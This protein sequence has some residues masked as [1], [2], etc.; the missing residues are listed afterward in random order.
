MNKAATVSSSIRVAIFGIVILFV[1]SIST[2]N[3]Q[4]LRLSGANY[5][6][7]WV[8][9][10]DEDTDTNY[11]EHL[12]DKIKVSLSYGD[13]ALRSAF[14]FSDPSLPNPK[15][16]SYID[17]SV[18][19]SKDPVNILYGRFNKTFG[20]GLV[21][22]QFV[23]EDFKIDKSLF[24]IQSRINYFN[25]Q[26]TLLSGKP[27]NVFFEENTYGI[28]NDDDTTAQVRG[29]DL[30]T[31][32]IPRITLGGRYVRINQDID[33]IPEA[34]TELFGGNIGFRTGPFDAYVE[35]AQQLG[36]YP[37]LGGRL[38]GS[39]VLFSSSLA[40]SGLGI[41]FQAMDYDTIGF[42][43]NKTYRYNE[44]VTPIK[45]GISVNRG[46]DEIGF[47]VSMLYS[48]F[49]FMTIELDNNKISTH[50]T[51]LNKIEQIFVT[52]ETMNAV[53]EQAA[54]ITTYPS[55]ELEITAAIEKI[56]KQGIEVPIVKKTETKPHLE[57][58]YNFGPFFVGSEY[59]IEYVSSDTSDY[60]D[61]ALALSI[62]KPEAFVFTVRYEKRSRAP[63]WLVD[64]EKIGAET[65]WPLAELS[66]DLT[67]R[68]N[69]RIRAGAE[70]GGLVCTGGVCRFEEPF[71]GIKLVLTSIF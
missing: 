44:P 41:S 30:E 5:G 67:T 28:K 14:F 24:G 68:H 10:E 7:Y 48:P 51:T 57:V 22:N 54:K 18:Q 53:I 37:G 56:V 17:Y 52:N 2:L 34:F 29:V 12:E 61:Q 11:K 27:R 35:Y 6:E 20:R 63:Q 21:L 23:D 38:K 55:Y 42:P 4:D 25:T 50:D 9:F 43:F 40:L 65:R 49:D 26:L 69:L 8:F 3:A 1:C 66:L 64:L 70:K 32:I 13:I 19:Y 60:Y 59:G 33:I 31:K 47:G 39:A 71:K 45:T 36:T 15:K 62:G 58:S 16:L 46:I